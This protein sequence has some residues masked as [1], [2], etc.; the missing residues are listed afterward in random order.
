MSFRFSKSMALLAALVS[1]T[2]VAQAPTTPAVD[3]APGPLQPITFT[4]SVQ[5]SFN[6]E[7]VVHRF[8][9]RRGEIIPFSFQITSTGKPLNLSVMLVSLRQEES[10]IIMHDVHTPPPQHIRFTTETQFTLAPGQSRT[11]AGEVT[12]PISKTN[13]L[14]YGVLVK[15]QGAVNEMANQTNPGDTERRASVRFVTQYLLRVDVQTRG[16]DIGDLGDLRLIN[17]TV[18]SVNGMPVAEAFLDNP[19]D[20]ALECMVRAEIQSPT[21][22][23]PTPFYLGLPSRASLSGAD[24]HLIRLMPRSRVRLFAPVEDM[25]VPGQQALALSLSFQQRKIVD[26]AFQ[27]NV[28]KGQFPALETKMAHLDKLLSA[29]P[30]QIELGHTRGS[31]RTLA[32]KLSNNS[33]AE[34]TLVLEPR[35]LNGEILN[36]V[37]LSSESFVLQPGRYKNIRVTLESSDRNA[38]EFGAIHVLSKSDNEVAPA[39]QLPIALLFDEPPSPQVDISDIKAFDNEGITSFRV[40]VSNKGL[41]YVPIDAELRISAAAGGSIAM[42]DGFGKWLAPGETRDLDFLPTVELTDGEYQLSLFIRTTP[43]AEVSTSTLN[44]TMPLL[45]K[46]TQAPSTPEPAGLGT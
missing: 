32:L 20:M 24:K 17:G 34:Q 40:S 46:G 7:P 5:R 4:D 41:G 3:A 33:N 36:G 39:G 9:G 27:L 31:R 8:D 1:S 30:A 35:G 11:L 21:Q 22:N 13:F 25:L 28:S 6:I 10:G 16:G 29:E 37:K 26:E 19:T 23:R 43:E 45:P 44:I 38:A 14:S 42:A 15:D 18:N 12:V 2:A